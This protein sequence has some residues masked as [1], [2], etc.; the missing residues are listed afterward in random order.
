MNKFSDW[1][2]G[3]L[4]GILG[5]SFGFV[6]MDVYKRLEVLERPRP[7]PFVIPHYVSPIIPPPPSYPPPL[8]PSPADAPHPVP[9]ELPPAEEEVSTT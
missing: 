2:A 7:A 8:P 5:A 6:S 3:I 9:E 4:F 1:I